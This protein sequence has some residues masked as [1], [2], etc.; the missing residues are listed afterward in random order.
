MGY[1]GILKAGRANMDITGPLS[2]KLRT[3][4]G[5]LIMAH[6]FGL[7]CCAVEMMHLSTPRYDQDRLGIIFR[8]LPPVG[9]YDCGWHSHQQDGSRTTTSVRS[10]ARSTMGYFHGQLCQRRR[11]LSLQFI[12][13]QEV[14]DR[15]VPVDITYRDALQRQKR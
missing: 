7:A 10:D 13:S 5:K 6:D 15:I 4:L 1:M 14:C 11:I 2:I 8:A 3:G 9:R 12:P